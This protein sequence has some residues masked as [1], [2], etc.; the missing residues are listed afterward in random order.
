LLEPFPITSA[1]QRVLF[2]VAARRESAAKP[3]TFTMDESGFI[4]RNC[5][6]E[7]VEVYIVSPRAPRDRVYRWS[8]LTVGPKHVDEEIEG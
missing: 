1:E 8:A 2:G 7:E 6:D 4:H 3:I 5:A